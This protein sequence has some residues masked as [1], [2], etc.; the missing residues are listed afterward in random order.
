MRSSVQEKPGSS[1][2]NALHVLLLFKTRRLLRVADVADELGVARSTAHR[3]LVA[4]VQRGF[5]VQDSITR[6]YLPGPELTEIGLSVVAMLDIREQ[7]R[8]I[9]NALSE[10]LHETVSLVVLEGPN[11]R[12]LDS[13][14]GDFVVR[15][16]SRTGQVLPAHCVSGGKALLSGLD[17]AQIDAMYTTEELPTLTPKSISTKT[18][19]LA[20]LERIRTAGYSTNA[21]ESEP[22]VSAVAVTLVMGGSRAAITVA[23]PTSRVRARDTDRLGREVLRIVREQLAL[24]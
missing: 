18:A 4:M 19:L 6:A 16:G 11:A 9:M 13:V 1:V 14:E 8:P 24:I 22:D 21:A 17:R 5:A 2:D 20:E 7:A 15:V 3:L 23:A 12:F 10:A